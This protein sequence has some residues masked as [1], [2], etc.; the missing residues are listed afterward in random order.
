MI[1]CFRLLLF[2]KTLLLRWLLLK[3]VAYGLSYFLVT[4]NKSKFLMFILLT[5]NR[6]KISMV[7]LLTLNKSKILVAILLTLNNNNGFINFLVIIF[8]YYIKKKNEIF[9]NSNL[10]IHR[11]IIYFCLLLF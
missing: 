11:I 6:S 8:L 5:L 3:M 2:L 9:Y 10:G 7:T 4:L 1:I